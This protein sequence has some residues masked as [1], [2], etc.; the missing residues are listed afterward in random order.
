MN[1]SRFEK[2]YPPF[3]VVLAFLLYGN[4][5][6]NKYCFDDKLV[7]PLHPQVRQGIMGIPSI[8]STNYTAGFTDS[9]EYRPFTKATF[10]IEYELFGENTF[11]SHLFNVLLYCLT[12]L[13]LYR[14]TVFLFPTG[15]KLFAFV[16]V[17]LFLVHPA[18]TEAVSSLKNRE[19]LLSFLF[20]ILSVEFFARS[21]RKERYIYFIPASV[22]FIFS[23]F[24]KL[25]ALPFILI[26]PISMFYAGSKN[27][28]APVLSF[29]TLAILSF[30]FFAGVNY[31]LPGTYNR[32]VYFIEN[33]MVI[34]SS[35]TIIF[36]NAL[37]TMWL[38]IKLCFFPHPLSFYYGYDV[39][40][41]AKSISPEIIAAFLIYGFL[42]I[43]S[44]IMIRKRE[45][46]AF[47][48]LFF[49]LNLSMYVNLVFPAPGILAD[50]ALYAA[51]FGFS[52][53][54]SHS[55]MRLSEKKL[56]LILT[57]ILA[58]SSVKT[59]LRNFDWK[60]NLTLL[61]K[62]IVHLKRS[63]KANLEYATV[64]KD[65]WEN[66]KKTSEKEFY[67]SKAIYYYRE[68][69]GVKPDMA[70]PN[71]E[72][73]KILFSQY[74]NYEEA[75]ELFLRAIQ[76]DSKAE[77]HFNLATCFTLQEEYEKAEKSFLTAIQLEDGYTKAIHNLFLV[78]MAQQKF[79]EAFQIN[80]ILMEKIPGDAYPYFNFGKFYIATGD[81]AKAVLHFEK[82]RSIEPQ[83]PAINSILKS[84]G[85]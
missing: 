5:L 38:Y 11:I 47:A 85:K 43:Y 30:I 52:L 75:E 25:T 56:I 65:R 3:I 77:F 24:T 2:Y 70:I 81:T 74:R 73:G 27:L 49:L 33:P 18:H 78:Y 51:S 34:E 7:T 84:L 68:S 55:A 60:D 31:F 76:L 82:A 26:I 1:I 19:D 50:R 66:V 48:F 23:L 12:C 46:L 9:F 21:V 32:N 63:A 4:T 79:G 58:I 54:I 67:A 37:Q 16:A 57:P 10:A 15:G 36:L 71:N 17:L 40:P 69:L 8:F 35:F 72:I 80:S 42:T 41:V 59:F 61:G 20:C 39:F 64:L 22:F 13:L 83:N 44:V 45:I 14:L 6:F 29:V 28:K 62:D 53:A